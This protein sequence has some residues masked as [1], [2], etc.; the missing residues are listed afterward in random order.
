[1]NLFRTSKKRLESL[2]T[3]MVMAT[4]PAVGSGAVKQYENSNPATALNDLWDRIITRA[5]LPLLGALAGIFLVL[6]GIQYIASL[7]NA[8]KAKRARQNIIYVMIAIIII[9]AAYAI[10]SSI[11]VAATFLANNT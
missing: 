11:L 10:I 5:A 2:A 9:I 3:R 1:M 7:G 6:A 4:I 8:E